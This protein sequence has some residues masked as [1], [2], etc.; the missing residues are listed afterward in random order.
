VR[1]AEKLLKFKVESSLF[2]LDV[3]EY[4]F[5]VW[6][7]SAFILGVFWIA[8]LAFL[9]LDLTQSLQQYKIHPGKSEK[10]GT[11]RLLEVL[12]TVLFNQAFISI[13]F[14]SGAYWLSMLSIGT[15]DMRA[16]PSFTILIRD[17]LIAHTLFD[18]GFYILH[19]AMHTKYF[20]KRIHKIHHEWKAP[21]GLVAIYAHPTEHLIT[22]LL[23]P[24]LGPVTMTSNVCTLWIWFAT[25][26][27]STVSDHSG[28]HLPFLKSPEFHDHHHVTFTECFGSC[29]IMD[30]IFGTDKRFRRSINFKRH[31]VLLSLR[32]TIRDVYPKYYAKTNE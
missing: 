26:A 5:L 20:Y 3:N 4:D 29:G 18:V 24:M 22:N 19:R 32:N 31:R 2:V 7:T 6:V 17:L 25:V 21:I 14:S 27:I 15:Q 9:Y 10:L 12:F 16:V 23:P 28:Y 8:M 11:R 30:F 1:E 13:T